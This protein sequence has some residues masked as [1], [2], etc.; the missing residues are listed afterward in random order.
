MKAIKDYIRYNSFIRKHAYKLLKL[1]DKFALYNKIY[2]KNIRAKTSRI[3]PFPAELSIET[4]NLCNAK[5][6]ICPHPDMK[7]TKSKMGTGLVHSLIEQAGRGK[8]DKLFLSG[9]GEPLVDNRLPQFIEYASTRGIKNITIVTNGSLLTPQLAESMIEAGLNEII[10]SIDG[11]TA[12]TYESIRLGLKF[13]R[14]VDN[15]NGL[16]SIKNRKDAE[17]SLS[18]VDLI[19]NRNERGKAY[20]EFGRFVDNIFFRQ[21]QGWTAGYGQESAGYSPHFETNSIPCQYLWNSASVY[22]DGTVPACCLD[23]E[24]EGVMGNAL[25]DSLERIWQGERFRY[26]RQ[27]HLNN[28]KSELVPCRKCG[29]YSVWW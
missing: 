28:H 7:R 1:C 9:F 27:Q 26:Y 29:Y 2:S 25:D 6:T 16:S 4:T 19:H 22:I 23:F 12:K 8:V 5:C 3:T 11:F 13:E 14:L 24:A 18:C 15:L 10:I 21:A 20:T 17:I